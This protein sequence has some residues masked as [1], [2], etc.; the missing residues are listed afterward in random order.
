MKIAIAGP[1]N[2]KCAEKYFSKDYNLPNINI[3]ASSVNIYVCA[4]LELGHEVI[5]F[6][7][8]PYHK[9]TVVYIG[10]RIKIYCISSKFRVRGF[11]RYR[12]H[13]RIQNYIQKEIQN[14]DILHAEWTYEYALASLKY[15]EQKPVF[16]SVRDWCPY[17]LSIVK[18]IKNKCYWY[19]N[20]YMFKK[21]MLE[22]KVCFIANSNYT[23]NNISEDYP[24]NHVVMIPNP[25]QSEFIL[26]KREI[27]PK[28]PVFISISNSLENIRK[29]YKVL[30]MAFQDYLKENETARLILIGSY[31]ED[32]KINMQQ[33]GLL[34]NV[35][36]KGSLAHDEVF[37]ILDCASCLIHPSLEETFGN[38]FLEAMC[39]KVICIGGEASGAVPQILGEGKYGILC[40]ITNPSSIVE[41]M[42]QTENKTLVSKIVSDCTE[43]LEMKYLDSKV[44]ETHIQLFK[45]F[46]KE[47]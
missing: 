31:G 9:K 22:Q 39:R 16:C 30:L 32:W 6:T 44:A 5:V 29:N 11:G 20:F 46:Q 23:K 37:Q 25:V 10:D 1:F 47:G 26:K 27:Y 42:R 15:V 17:I 38:I 35:E 19:M 2:P 12:M 7:S 40:D 33:N 28:N 18:G 4:L 34:K 45:K 21:V 41:A 8:D 13:K 43:Y 3:T 24:D 14:I 36:L